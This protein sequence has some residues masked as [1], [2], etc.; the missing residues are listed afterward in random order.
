MRRDT[1]KRLERAIGPPPGRVCIYV[2]GH[3]LDATPGMVN[4][5]HTGGK[6]PIE[7]CPR[8]K[9]PHCSD[10]IHI[11]IQRVKAGPN[12]EVVVLSPDEPEEDDDEEG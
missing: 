10:F 6:I 4:C 2:E 5:H 7:D 9:C 1:L 12:G 8:S 3:A 11:H